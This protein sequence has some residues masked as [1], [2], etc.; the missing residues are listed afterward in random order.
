MD[1]KQLCDMIYKRRSVRKYSAE[2]ISDEVLV[3]IEAAFSSLRPLYPEIKVSLRIVSR[4]KV[5]SLMPWMPPYAV[6]IYSEDTDGSLENV[7]FI[8]EQLDL[9]IQSLG[10]GSCWV[11]LGRVKDEPVTEDGLKFVMLL[12]IGNTSVPEREG[13]SDFSRKELSDISDTADER[14]VPALLAPSSVNSQP[15][16]F[17]CCDEGYNVYKRNH[18]RTTGLS[19]MNMIDVGI[20]L[21][22]LYVSYPDSF[23]AS[24][25]DTPPER[26]N[27]TYVCTVGI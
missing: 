22:H 11:G 7:G 23:K 21:S 6:A 20:A 12:A 19:R 17:E 4:E 14:L 2:P 8:L 16:Y 15:W 24:R 1:T 18:V 26:K 5:R 9:Y 27:M 25:R 13:I 10:I 3:L